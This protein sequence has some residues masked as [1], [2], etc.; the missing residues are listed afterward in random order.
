MYFLLLA[1]ICHNRCKTY[2]P[3][4]HYK[5]VCRALVTEVGD[6][7]LFLQ[8]IKDGETEQM[9]LSVDAQASKQ[10]LDQLYLNDWVSR[11]SGGHRLRE[12]GKDP[13]LSDRQQLE[14][15]IVSRCD[16]T[17]CLQYRDLSY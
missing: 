11:V 1:Q 12:Q 2:C 15:G 16:V 10:E 13:R 4:S 5:A 8:K 17:D 3:E 14:I 7:K 9:R 6:L